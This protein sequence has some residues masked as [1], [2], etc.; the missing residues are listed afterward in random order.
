[1]ESFEGAKMSMHLADVKSDSVVISLTRAKTA[2][3]EV[4]TVQQTKKIIDM[5][6]AA[7][8]YA[9][10]Q[11]LGEEV[12]G[13]ATS[14]KIEALRKLGEMLNAA[15]KAKGGKPYQKATGATSEPVAPTL[16]DLGLTKKESA[17][18]QKLAALPEKAFQEVQAGH[19]TIAKAI[20]AVNARKPAKPAKKS[21]PAKPAE[22][23]PDHPAVAE[24][25]KAEEQNAVLA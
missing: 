2:L 16:D 22:P 14:I 3:A 13:Q 4:L 10:R 25:A 21:K 12:A 7:E 23:A 17:V 8:I 20:A 9:K 1:V 5:A 18:A 19:T 11:H 24:L 6:A 15:P